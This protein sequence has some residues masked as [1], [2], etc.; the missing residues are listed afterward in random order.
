MSTV[1]RFGAMLGC[2]DGRCHG[3][4][5]AVAELQRRFGVGPVD[6]ITE[7]AI[8]KILSGKDGAYQ[9]FIGRKLM[10]SL[11]SHN[12]EC[13][14]IVGHTGC[15]VNTVPDEEQIQQIKK[16]VLALKRWRDIYVPIIG[17]FVNEKGQCEVIVE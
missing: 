4:D 12:A 14:G 16:S 9:E 7:P 11:R 17:L 5:A 3:D 13:I 10:I 6:R 1:I 2:I 15:A 8:I